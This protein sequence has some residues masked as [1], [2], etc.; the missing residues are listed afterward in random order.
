[1]SCSKIC[2]YISLLALP[3]LL[4]ACRE[5]VSYVVERDAL[6]SVGG[7][8][9]YKDEVDIVYAQYAGRVDSAA[10]VQDYIE[11]WVKEK[12]FFEKAV[13]NVQATDEIDKLVE[14]YRKSL[15]LNLYQDRLITQHLVPV[16]S[17][18]EVLQFY[19]SERSLFFLSDPYI[20]GFYV[21]LPPKAANVRDVR[22]WCVKRGQENLDNL[23]KYCV[24]KGCD[25]LFFMEEWLPFDVLV[26][27][28]PLTEQQL[29]DRLEKNSTIEFKDGGA[30]YF[31]CADSVLKR[32]DLK[33]IEMVADE[34]RELLVNRKKANFVKDVK[35]ALYK[36][37]LET[38]HVVLH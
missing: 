8:S 23:E 33:P 10:F 5:E 14:N 4:F 29:M 35:S 3:A 38:G 21:K 22:K 12:L 17:D 30:T 28:T 27:K 19:E 15:I 37:A 24:E 16:I 20:K 7:E 11:R 6:A 32:N 18:E 26:H 36:E 2:K 9:L 13:G 31:V 25:N 34:I 1:M